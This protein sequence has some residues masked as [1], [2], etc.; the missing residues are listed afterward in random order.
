MGGGENLLEN[1]KY[2]QNLEKPIEIKYKRNKR[3]EKEVTVLE[4][5]RKN[6]CI[7][8]WH[9]NEKYMHSSMTPKRKI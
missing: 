9:Q 4:Y 8:V 2:E 7:Q 5:P 1:R 6:T 3:Q